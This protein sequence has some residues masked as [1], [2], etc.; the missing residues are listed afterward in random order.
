MQRGG[1]R[2]HWSSS[3]RRLLER[4]PFVAGAIFC[5]FITF[6]KVFPPLAFRFIFGPV[7]AIDLQRI[8]HGLT[9]G[10]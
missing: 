8:A 6:I 1:D 3:D 9:R 10:S 2:I 4:D 5:T 7:L